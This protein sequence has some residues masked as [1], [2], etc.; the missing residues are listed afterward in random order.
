VRLLPAFDP[1]V[2][3]PGTAD[4]HVVPPAQRAEV[5]RGANL[6]VSGGV[7]SGTWSAAK[8]GAVTV[9]WFPEAKR[10]P[11]RAVTEE[12]ERLSAILDR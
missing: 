9:T 2:M 3:G 7:V 12:V 11:E 1:W 4:S 6:V 5:S 10:P 8:G